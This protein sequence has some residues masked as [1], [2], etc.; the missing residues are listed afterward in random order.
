MMHTCTTGLLFLAGETPFVE[1]A[2][3]PLMHRV[4]LSGQKAGIRQWQVLTWHDAQRVYASLGADTRVRELSCQVYDMHQV[5]PID[6]AR[7]LPSAES[8]VV[9]CTAVFDHRL[10][11]TLQQCAGIALCVDTDS[12]AAS[13]FSEAV[14]VS[15]GRVLPTMA[16]R[17]ATCRTTGLLRCQG[18]LLERM[19]HETWAVM[20]QVTDP[21]QPLI[22][23]LLTCGHVEAV[24]VR[25]YFWC[26][27][28]SPLPVSTAQAETH[29]LRSSGRSGDSL[30]VRLLD[31]RISQTLTRRLVRTPVTP[32]QITL[33]SAALGLCGAALLAQPVY[34]WQVLGS[35]LFLLSTIIDGCDGEVARLTFQESAFG[36]KLDTIMD[37][38]VHLFLFPG[39]ALGLYRQ[40]H[41]TLYLGLGAAA[42]GGSLLSMVV[43]LP[44]IWHRQ[45]ASRGHAWLHESL[46]SRDFTYVL[47]LLTLAGMLRWFLWASAIGTYAFAIAWL[48]LAWRA[49]RQH[50]ASACGEFSS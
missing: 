32:N 12:P 7:V 5:K 50:P 46:A 2:G 14:T 45:D 22:Q 3:L 43:F 17:G 29:L 30:L 13:G 31:R 27:L 25:P 49:R 38:V 6:M 48:V 19:M 21:L 37:N 23:R 18:T 9:S 44:H 33:F 28:T 35:F 47:L 10:L 20:R 26:P 39:I 15:D 41:E 4:L 1:V 40:Q 42:L 16:T 8:L 34:A 36:A 24:D 11:L